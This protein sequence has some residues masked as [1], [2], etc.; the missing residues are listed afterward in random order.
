M[1]PLLAA[2]EISARDE[3]ARPQTM[4]PAFEGQRPVDSTSAPAD[5]QGTLSGAYRDAAPSTITMVNG[6]VDEM[7]AKHNPRYA[8]QMAKIESQLASYLAGGTALNPVIESAIYSRARSKNN[9]ESRRVRDAAYGEAAGRGFTMP[10]GALMSAMQQGRQAAADNNTKASADIAIAQAEMEQKN[11]QF[12][13]TTSVGLR[14]AILDASLAHMQGIAAL[15]GQALEYAKTVL[16]AVV[17]TYNVSLR[18]FSAKMEVYKADAQVFEVKLRGA[19][20]GIELYRAEVSAME[21]LTQVDRSKVDVYRARIESLGALAGV[22]RS[23]IEAVVGRASLEKLKLDLFQ[24][25]VQGF[26]AQVQAKNA[27]WQGYSAAVEG[28]TAKVKMF[29]GQAEAF[30]AR[31][32]GFKATV[33]AQAEAVKAMATTNDSRARNYAAQW[34]GYQTVV[35]S[36]GEVART[37]LENQ[38]QE[39]VA[40]QAEVGL[41]VANAQVGAEYYRATS[42]VAVENA[43]LKLSGQV[44][45]AESQRAFGETLARLGTANAQIYA[46]LANSA[47]SGMNTLAAETLAEG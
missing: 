27:E 35:Q 28:Q 29:A 17:E 7:M 38:R 15:N 1:N 34:A 36:L 12:A 42:G 10:H 5:L 2:P 31:V 30:S 19:M 46:G 13:V 16:S 21:A 4:L 26:T 37:K 11:L 47:L 3:P 33:E 40:F 24:S 9:A 45:G 41:A 20:A 14:K 43:R 18:A 25:Q 22:Y 44:Q 6:Y 32:Q 23:Q 39:V 8:E